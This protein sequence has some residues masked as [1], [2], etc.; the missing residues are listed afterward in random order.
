MP[1]P[2]GFG[3]RRERRK[4]K[5]NAYLEFEVEGSKPALYEEFLQLKYFRET[6]Q[7]F[8]LGK[9]EWAKCLGVHRRTLYRWEAQLIRLNFALLKEY[10]VPG[11][12][13]LDNYQRFILL[14]IASK[15]QSGIKDPQ[16]KSWL[17]ENLPYL[18]REEFKKW[19]K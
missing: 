17:K 2:K 1:K 8:S 18:T 5:S 3:W 7:D 9:E 16:L 19:L 6:M 10:K 12:R 13:H 11:Q 4:K 14:L 15:K